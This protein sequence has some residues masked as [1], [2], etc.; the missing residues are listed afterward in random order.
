[1]EP[2]HPGAPCH[3]SRERIFLGVFAA[4]DEKSFSFSASYSALFDDEHERDAEDD[5]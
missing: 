4:T 2:T 5:F 1:M 3:P